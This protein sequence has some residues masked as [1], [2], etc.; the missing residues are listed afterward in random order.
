MSTEARDQY[1][2]ILQGLYTLL[3]RFPTRNVELQEQTDLVAD[4]GLDSINVME[5][6]QEIE[7]RFDIIVPLNVMSDIRTVQELA[8]QVQRLIGENS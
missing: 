4:M 3:A 5:L 1:Q 7:D 8:I 2:E 6:L